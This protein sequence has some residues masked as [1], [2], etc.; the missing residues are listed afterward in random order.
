MKHV[1]IIITLEEYSLLLAFL[2]KIFIKSIMSLSWVGAP[3]TYW[4]QTYELPFVDQGG[5]NISNFI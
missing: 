4:I 2:K 5:L 3:G 1:A